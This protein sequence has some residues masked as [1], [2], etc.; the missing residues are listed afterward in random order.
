MGVDVIVSSSRD[1]DSG[2]NKA[3]GSPSPYTLEAKLERLNTKSCQGLRAHGHP[4]I[5]AAAH[6]R[7]F[8]TM[9][10]HETTQCD[11]MGEA[12]GVSL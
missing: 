11:L 8:I 4:K 6:Q 2:S 12:V 9:K 10:D 5:N 7:C 3:S 1:N